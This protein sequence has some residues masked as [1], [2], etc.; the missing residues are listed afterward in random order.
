M[1]TAAVRAMR[2]KL[3][4][5]D[6]V[7]HRRRVDHYVCIWYTPEATEIAHISDPNLAR[8]R[9]RITDGSVALDKRAYGGWLEIR[10]AAGSLRAVGEV[11]AIGE[12]RHTWWRDA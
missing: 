6:S 5:G 11:S 1:A 9:R 3:T 10:D 7:R 8:I 4:T 12:I 2:Q